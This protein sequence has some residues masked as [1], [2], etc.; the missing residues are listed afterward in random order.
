MKYLVC[1][2]VALLFSLSTGAVA[3]EAAE[4]GPARLVALGDVYLESQYTPLCSRLTCCEELLV[5]QQSALLRAEKE[6]VFDL[7]ELR[8]SHLSL[9]YEVAGLKESLNDAN[10]QISFLM[11][12]LFMC[13]IVFP[14][15]TYY[16]A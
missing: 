16:L 7:L 6:Y 5:K 14:V 8:K 12:S 3:M 13:N 2:H 11:I 9:K 15:A 10:G 1:F 4:D